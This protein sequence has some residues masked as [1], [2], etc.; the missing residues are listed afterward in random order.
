MMIAVA[1]CPTCG[2]V[3][4]KSTR[5]YTRGERIDPASFE[6]IGD[7]PAPDPTKPAL[8]HVCAAALAFRIT[9][10][11]V[12][13]NKQPSRQT[14]DVGATDGVVT[15]LFTVNPGEE[16]KTMRESGTKVLIITNRRIVTVDLDAALIQEMAS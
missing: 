8:C 13:S 4:Y 2:E 3:R 12:L 15:T 5:E 6:P 7:A 11:S 10:P 1:L 14:L 9:D 16:I